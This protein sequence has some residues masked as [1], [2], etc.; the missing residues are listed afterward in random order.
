M[1]QLQKETMRIFFLFV[2][3]LNL[4]VGEKYFLFLSQKLKMGKFLVGVLFLLFIVSIIIYTRRRYWYFKRDVRA[5]MKKLEEKMPL[6]QVD[7]G[8]ETAK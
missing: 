7:Q 4:A 8:T 1:K 5:Y 3:E 6:N 2:P